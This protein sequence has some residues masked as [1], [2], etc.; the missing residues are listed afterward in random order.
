MRAEA[1][2]AEQQHRLADA[3]ELSEPL[4]ELMKAL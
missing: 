1:D 3:E 2:L 4:R